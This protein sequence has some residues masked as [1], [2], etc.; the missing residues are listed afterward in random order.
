MNT[1]ECAPQWLTCSQPTARFN[2]KKHAKKRE[3]E[4]EKPLKTAIIALARLIHPCSK[5]RLLA[6]AAAAAAGVQPTSLSRAVLVNRAKL[7]RRFAKLSTCIASQESFSHAPW[8]WATAYS[9]RAKGEAAI[10]PGAGAPQDFGFGAQRVQR[11]AG[12]L[13]MAYY[14][15]RASSKSSRSTR[16]LLFVS[17]FFFFQ[18]VTRNDGITSGRTVPLAAHVRGNRFAKH[19]NGET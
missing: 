3:R 19:V 17:S 14:P 4:I 11:T 7:Q 2:S 5:K 10:R 18:R 15:Q 9:I 13:R 1:A 8:R 12:V 16:Q 6:A